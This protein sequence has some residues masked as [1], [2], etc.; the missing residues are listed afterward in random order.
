MS[1]GTFNKVDASDE[2]MYGPRGI[3]VCG[4]P[5]EEHGPLAGFLETLC[6]RDVKVV[7]AGEALLQETLR[8]ILALPDRSGEGGPSGLPR[9]MVLSGLSQKELHAL[10]AAYRKSGLPGQL[11][12]ALTPTSETWALEDLLKELAREAEAMRKKG[13]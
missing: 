3:V 11:W 4:Y 8:D 12:A 6:G 9:G 10:M 1:R 13:R 5:P 2:R 7:F